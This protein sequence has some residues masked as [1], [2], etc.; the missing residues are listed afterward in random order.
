MLPHRYRA[1]DS[2]D[3]AC[4]PSCVQQV[5]GVPTL[6]NTD[7]FW[8]S[9]LFFQ[10][11][12]DNLFLIHSE[13]KLSFLPARCAHQWANVIWDSPCFSRHSHKVSINFFICIFI[14]SDWYSIITYSY[15]REL[16]GNFIGVC[17]N[18][19][20]CGLAHPG[21]FLFISLSWHP[22]KAALSTHWLI[23]RQGDLANTKAPLTPHS[24]NL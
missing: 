13:R 14:V 23:N 15:V 24:L 6:F 5:I 21:A 1:R 2:K 18:Q 22:K 3:F 20:V 16:A 9:Y 19:I 17:A 8:I 11:D 12:V 4:M 10:L 7:L